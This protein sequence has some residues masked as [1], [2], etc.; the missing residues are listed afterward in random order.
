MKRDLE[1]VKKT[2][3]H[4]ENLNKQFEQ[5]IKTIGAFQPT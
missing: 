2:N 4:V 5:R 3:M 1:L